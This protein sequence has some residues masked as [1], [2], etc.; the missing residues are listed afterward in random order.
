MKESQRILLAGFLMVLVYVLWSIFL[1]PPAL[2]ESSIIA[3]NASLNSND[4]ESLY[5]EDNTPAEDFS[6]E[7]SS[8]FISFHVK[9]D[10]FSA[11][12]S[13]RSG[14]TF[15]QYFLNSYLGSYSGSTVTPR[16][17]VGYDSSSPF[18]FLYDSSGGFSNNTCTDHTQHCSALGRRGGRHCWPDQRSRVHPVSRPKTGSPGTLRLVRFVRLLV[19]RPPPRSELRLD[20]GC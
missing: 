6:W 5:I 7:E 17:N 10:T 11:Q 1:A 12:L 19:A 8:E 18:G 2:K 16:G 15:S 20:W 14:G 3:N 4:T 13:S 9:G